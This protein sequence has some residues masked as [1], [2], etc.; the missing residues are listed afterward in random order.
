MKNNT[1]ITK[2]L[3]N[4]KLNITREFAAPV[5]KVWRAWTESDLLDKWWAPKPYKAVTQIMD[6]SEGG[7]WLYNMVGPEH[8]VSHCCVDFKTINP[9]RSF[10]N[11]VSFCNEDGQIDKSFPTMHWLVAFEGTPI[12]SKVQVTITFDAEA[13]LEK[14][15]GMGFEQGFTMAIGN[16][17]ELLEA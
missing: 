12:G 14:I 16:L 11:D 6:F 15:I 4:R 17:D 3:T 10:T 13:D 1:S 7:I 2:D 9:L 5:E 8:D